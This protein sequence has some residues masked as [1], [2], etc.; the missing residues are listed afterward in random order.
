MKFSTLAKMLWLLFAKTIMFCFFSCFFVV[1]G[2]ISLCNNAFT[3]MIS[4]ESPNL[5]TK[6][7]FMLSKEIAFGHKKQIF[8][9]YLSVL[10]NAFAVGFSMLGFLLF[11]D[12]FF[13]IPFALYVAFVC[14]SM[15]LSWICFSE[16]SAENLFQQIKQD[17][18]KQKDAGNV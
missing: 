12:V 4:Y 9:Q 18:F 16:I 11:L 13:E 6:G 2:F 10:G 3:E 7:V 17:K 8:I 14:I 15:L 1:P 5:D